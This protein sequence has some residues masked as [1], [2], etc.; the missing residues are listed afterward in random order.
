MVG[1]RE[2]H[3]ANDGE[4]VGDLGLLGQPFANVHAGHAGADGPEIAA[5]LRGSVRLEIVHVDMTRTAFEPD[6][7]HGLASA[8]APLGLQSQEIGEGKPSHAQAAKLQ[9][10]ASRKPVSQG[11]HVVL[12]R[13]ID[14]HSACF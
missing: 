14:A 5:D 3:V 8:L 7:D 2:G 13:F 10:P 6:H 12:P 4:L 1:L 9:E 11:Q